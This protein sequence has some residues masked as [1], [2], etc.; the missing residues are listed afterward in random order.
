M[1]VERITIFRFA[2]LGV[3][4]FHDHG[5]IAD[6]SHHHGGKPLF[7]KAL[8]GLQLPDDVFYSSERVSDVKMDCR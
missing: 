6:A 4:C 8:T 1:A 5:M 7:I 3:G 2:R